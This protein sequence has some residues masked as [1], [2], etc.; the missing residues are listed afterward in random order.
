M[1]LRFKSS[2]DV[3]PLCR[4]YV[5]ITASLETTQ[6]PPPPP[7]RRE[8][9]YR[10]ALSESLHRIPPHFHVILVE[11]N[12]PRTTWLDGLLHHDQPV[13]VIY[14]SHNRLRFKS[15]GTNELL[16]IHAALRAAEVPLEAMVIK[17]TGRYHPINSSFF[18]AVEQSTADALI[19]FHQV[20]RGY[21]PNDCVLGMVALR[22]HYWLLW[23]AHTIDSYPSAEV[24]FARYVRLC[25]A[26]IQE[27]DHLGL[28]CVFF[29][30]QE[31]VET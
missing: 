27:M 7:G 9:E 12:G 20:R 30:D 5:V 31:V 15:K 23:R 24:A 16:D 14:T 17:L 8:A 26:R 28:R 2:N 19:K 10:S 13:R 18:E 6:H 4:M 29:E 11:N 22:C 21:D 3:S 25:G 1:L